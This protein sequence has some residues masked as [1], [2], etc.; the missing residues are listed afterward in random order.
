MA[1]NLIPLED[2]AKMLGKTVDELTDLR[3][4]NEIFGY[5]DGPSWKFKMEELKRFAGENGIEMSSADQDEDLSSDA[6]LIADSSAEV[7]LDELDVEIDLGTGSEG[8]LSSNESHVLSG[9]DADPG[10]SPSDTGKM[11][12]GDDELLLAEDD[13]FGADDAAQVIEDDSND[14]IAMDSDSDLSSDFGD[15][16][17]LMLDDDSSE[18]AL[19]AADS[20]INLSPTDSGLSLD[21]E[22]L[23]LGGSDIDA[24]ELP[25]DSEINLLEADEA[26]VGADVQADNDFMLT[27]LEADAEDESSGSQVIALEDSEI[28]DDESSEIVSDS[29]QM[30]EDV[31]ADALAVEEVVDDGMAVM[32]PDITASAV[33]VRKPQPAQ[34]MI[35]EQPIPAWMVAIQTI[36]LLFLLA[37]GIIVIDLG[38][39]MFEFDTEG[40]VT[41]RLTEYVIDFTGYFKSS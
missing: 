24:L 21:E 40:S 26:S 16:S 4:R 1:G 2:A 34:G 32:S 9:S 23:E 8:N 14:E 30:G 11:V 19:D 15:D 35:L 25:E 33:S 17:S 12:V 20:G 10:D 22:P 36:C 3:S 7:P 28:Y 27:P 39:N 18:I 13:L 5:R 41:A 37:A 29:S 31:F 6:G 38:R